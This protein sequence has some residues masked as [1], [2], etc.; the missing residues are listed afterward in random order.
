MAPAHRAGG[1]RVR[2]PAARRLSQ[3]QQSDDTAT[4]VDAQ[5]QPVIALQQPTLE[6]PEQLLFVEQ[7]LQQLFLL[8][9]FGEQLTTGQLRQPAGQPG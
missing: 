9:Q 7:L 3:R 5:F 6:P 4:P 8:Q 2:V 1:P